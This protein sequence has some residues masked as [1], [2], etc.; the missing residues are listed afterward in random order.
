MWTLCIVFGTTKLPNES[1]ILCVSAQI[2]RNIK[3]MCKS[4]E[5]THN[6]IIFLLTQFANLK[7]WLIASF[8]NIERIIR[9]VHGNKDNV[10]FI[11]PLLDPLL[12]LKRCRCGK[13]YVCNGPLTQL[14]ITNISYV[15]CLNFVGCHH[16]EWLPHSKLSIHQRFKERVWR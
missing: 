1:T 6:A 5:N 2:V 3:S 10:F 12:I 11:G 8:S 4:N 15:M 16:F 14:T 9:Q 13:L 7:H